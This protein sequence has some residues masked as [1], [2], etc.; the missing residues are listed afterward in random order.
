MPLSALAVITLFERQA[1][2]YEILGITSGD[3]ILDSLDQLNQ[4]SGQTIIE[5]ERRKIRARNVRGYKTWLGMQ[6][7]LMLAGTSSA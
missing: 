2:P 1:V 3:S 7:G 4:R 6:T 5:L